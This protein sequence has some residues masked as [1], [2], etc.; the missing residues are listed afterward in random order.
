MAQIV[1]QVSSQ[2][3]GQ[4]GGA[5]PRSPDTQSPSYN[6]TVQPAPPVFSAPQPPQVTQAPPGQWP[7]GFYGTSRPST[8]GQVRRDDNCEILRTP[9]AEL[10]QIPAF[11][12]MELIRLSENSN[13]V[14]PEEARLLVVRRIQA[15]S[16]QHTNRPG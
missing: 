1:Q 15:E 4:L 7:D 14:T 16:G 6:A 3:L 2:E 10:L 9:K 5:P 8:V 11:D 12:T 13:I